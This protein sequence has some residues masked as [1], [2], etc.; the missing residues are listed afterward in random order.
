M[1]MLED[2]TVIVV[3]HIHASK[4]VMIDI[5]IISDVTYIATPA[6]TQ[7]RSTRMYVRK[8]IKL[9]LAR[10]CKIASHVSWTP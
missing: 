9:E 1:T 6:K 7:Q 2:S 3:F 10:N 4:L 5:T 8:L